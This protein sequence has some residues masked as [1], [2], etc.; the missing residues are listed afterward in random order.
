LGKKCRG[1]RGSARTRSNWVFW[2]VQGQELGRQR[3]KEERKGGR[4][5]ERTMGMGKRKV[6]RNLAQWGKKI[7]VQKVLRKKKKGRPGGKPTGELIG[8]QPVHLR[9]RLGSNSKKVKK[10]MMLS[11]APKNLSKGGLLTQRGKGRKTR[12]TVRQ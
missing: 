5:K 6:P 7:G 2:H 4:F 11:E 8:S 3:G 1:G 10:S 9:R 12:R